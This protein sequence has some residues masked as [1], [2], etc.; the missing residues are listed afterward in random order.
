[1]ASELIQMSPKSARILLSALTG[2]W[3][4]G[5]FGVVELFDEAIER[6]QKLLKW[7]LLEGKNGVAEM[8]D[9][10]ILIQNWQTIRS[11]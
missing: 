6:Q 10:N 5:R 11:I 8:S 4:L 1:M 7:T 3:G 2:T 9:L